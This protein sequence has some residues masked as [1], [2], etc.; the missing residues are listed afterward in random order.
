MVEV[1]QII[2]FSLATLALVLLVFVAVVLAVHSKTRVVMAMQ[3]FLLGVAIVG[4]IQISIY[5]YIYNG[6]RAGSLLREHTHV[7]LPYSSHVSAFFW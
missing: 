3:P 1:V 4:G 2:S 6:D 5:I 7:H